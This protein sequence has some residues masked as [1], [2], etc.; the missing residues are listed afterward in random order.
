MF[1]VYGLLNQW[2]DQNAITI[3]GI[4]D[5]P[6]TIVDCGN[7]YTIYSLSDIQQISQP[8]RKALLAYH[9]VIDYF[10][11]DHAIIPMRFGSSFETTTALTDFVVKNNDN[12]VKKINRISGCSEMGINVISNEPHTKEEANNKKYASGIDYL[13]KR[14]QHYEQI[15]ET[16]NYIK[17]VEKKNSLMNLKAYTWKCSKRKKRL[18][19]VPLYGPFIFWLKKS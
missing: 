19:L 7:L 5:Q 1:I 3:K 13:T 16:I 15:D 2:D 8:T 12:F 18:W 10:H 4:S 14:K 6:L 11:K 9:H 17:D